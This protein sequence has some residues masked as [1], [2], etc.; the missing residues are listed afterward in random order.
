M[1]LDAQDW[2]WEQ[3][4]AKG[5]A[6][7]V[8]LAIADKASGQD[9]SAYAGMTFLI[10]R[11]NAARSSVITSVDKLLASGELEIVEG[12]RGPHGETRYRL[13]K[14]IGYRRK[15][16]PKS[17]PVQNPDRSENRTP[18]GPK[19]VPP[20]SGNRTPTG[21]ETGPHNA[22][23][24]ETP[25]G[26]QKEGAGAR[27]ATPPQPTTAQRPD[28]RPAPIDDSGFELTDAMRRW[29][30]NTFGSTLD[31]DY[32]TQQFINHHRA[33]GRTRRSWPD[34]WQKW[35]RRSAKWASERATH[36]STNVVP[37]TQPRP[38]TTDARVQA[39]L[40]LGRQM[41]AEY[42]AAQTTTHKEAR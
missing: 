1:S 19:S 17:G 23:N 24:A 42:D 25:E 14:A 5:T 21:P 9:C 27:E 38:S 13:P 11:S 41:Q 8:L 32:E 15:G 20:R 12:R 7:L 39:A 40:D 34:E 30:L 28:G 33:E 31:V 37:F 22:V 2:V 36:P 3:A 26:T 18:G 16:G 6:R 10:Q 4:H 35:M 29:A